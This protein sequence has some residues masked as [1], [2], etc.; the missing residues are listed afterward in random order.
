MKKAFL[1]TT[2]TK[3]L[4]VLKTFE[5]DDEMLEI[6]AL[7]AEDHLR[8]INENLER[9]EQNPNNREALLEIRRSSHTLKGSA[10]IV[11]LKRLSRLAHKVED[12]LD[13]ISEHEIDSNEEIFQLLLA[14]TDC[15]AVLIR[16]ENLAE[17]EE[18]IIAHI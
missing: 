2:A 10:G 16:D 3:D 6:F 12:L 18:Q 9:L 5:I 7:E 11:G 4:K 17:Y 1:R 14:A 13:F 15:I 8:N